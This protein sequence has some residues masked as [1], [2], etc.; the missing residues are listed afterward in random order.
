MIVTYIPYTV[1][2]DWL[3][4]Q[5]LSLCTFIQQSLHTHHTLTKLLPTHIHTLTQL[6]P[7]HIHTL[8]H[9]GCLVQ[10]KDL[11]VPYAWLVLAAVVSCQVTS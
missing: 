9:K 8:T 3:A 1:S 11:F 5:G 7:T 6:L 10:M 2:V 4:C